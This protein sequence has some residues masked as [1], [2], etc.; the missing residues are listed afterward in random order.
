MFF[1][2]YIDMYTL[3]SITMLKFINMYLNF[4]TQEL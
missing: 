4:D 2:F 1:F 3:Y